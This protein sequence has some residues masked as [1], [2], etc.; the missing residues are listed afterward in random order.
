[1][2]KPES[3]NNQSTNLQGARKVK[4]T[5]AY[6]GSDY[7]GWQR[8]VDGIP[9]IQ[10]VMEQAISR[11]VKHPM[12]L[13]ASG[14][15]DTGVH[16][17][18]QVACF[19]TI[20]PIPEYRM[21][22]AINSRLPRDIRIVSAQPVDKGFDAIGSAQSKLYRYTVFNHPN[23]PPQAARYCYH[24]YIPC[25]LAPMQTAA[26]MLIGEHDFASFAA[27]GH[28]RKTTVRK[29]LRCQVSRQYNWLYF[30]IEATGFLYHMVRNIVGTLLDI[31]RGFWPPERIT[32][33]LAARDRSAA[34]PMVPPNGL[35]LQWVRY[36]RHRLPTK[37]DTGSLL[38]P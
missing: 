6:D 24:Y 23:L 12:S 10:Q 26:D 21:P 17:A 3:S 2:L 1:M 8:Q 32:D 31:G 14:R 19:R 27:S 13:R 38:T 36:R 35:C 18:G 34:G 28:E 11:L 33:I 9:T 16:A 29:L 37:S 15:T 30:D 20:S 5:I 7:N 22:H 25:K 4:L